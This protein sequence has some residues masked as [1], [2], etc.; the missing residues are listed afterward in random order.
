MFRAPVCP[1]IE[2][3]LLEERHVPS[4]FALMD[5]DRDYLREWLAF[6]DRTR[7]EADWRKFIR[8]SL[9]QFAASEGFNAG[10]WEGEQFLG[11]IGTKRIDWSNGRV[12]LGYWIGR[13]FQGRGIVTSACR[14]VL[15]Y[16]FHDLRM[17]RVEIQCASGNARSAAIPRRLGFTFEGTRREAEFVNGKFYDVLVFSILRKEWAEIRG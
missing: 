1:G 7:T 9:E 15:D 8:A 16:L 14:V 12:E 2:L 3:R 17:H 5:R 10:I 4:V 13:A 11:V 6:V